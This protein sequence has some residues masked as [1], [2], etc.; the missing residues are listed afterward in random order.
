MP[1]PEFDLTSINL[2]LAA[3][4]SEETAIVNVA[5]DFESGKAGTEMGGEDVATKLALARA[6]EEMGDHDQARELLEEVIA[7]GGG[8]L[9]EQ[10]RQI[11]GRLNG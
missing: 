6:Y 7:E 3:N 11:L 4:P 1:V 9:A 10:A 5:E 2:D 8:D